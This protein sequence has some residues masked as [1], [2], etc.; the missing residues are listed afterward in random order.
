[1]KRKKSRQQR[2][3]ERYTG[4]YKYVGPGTDYKGPPVDDVD[5]AAKRH[6][7]GYA[8]IPNPYWKFNKADEEFLKDIAKSKPA[9]TWWKRRIRDQAKIL[10]TAKK[11]LGQLSYPGLPFGMESERN[12]QLI[13]NAINKRSMGEVQS[14]SLE[15]RLPSNKRRRLPPRRQPPQ[16]ALPPANPYEEKHEE[17]G[18]VPYKKRMRGRAGQTISNDASVTSSRT[19]RYT[20]K[21]KRRRLRVPRSLRQIAK[22]DRNLSRRIKKLENINKV[23]TST[24]IYK[25]ADNF[26][27][28]CVDGECAYTD[29]NCIVTADYK[30]ALDRLKFFD[31][32]TP[33]TLKEVDAAKAL[34]STSAN[35]RC[36]I[37][38]KCHLWMKNNYDHKIIVHVYVMQAKDAVSAVPSTILSNASTEVLISNFA[39]NV[40]HYPDELFSTMSWK[41]TYKVLKKKRFTITGGGEAK[42]GHSQFIKSYQANLAESGVSYND[43]SNDTLFLI[44]IQG[45]VAHDS[46]T[47]TLGS[48]GPGTV[49]ILKFGTMKVRYNGGMS[50]KYFIDQNS[51]ANITTAIQED[52]D[53]DEP[54]AH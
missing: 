39:T 32:S 12:N 16:R 24:L 49:D 25:F 43:I 44:R 36:Q 10:F 26:Q 11:I 18:L 4:G 28:T 22:A 40:F 50:V 19:K 20:R 52:T 54:D 6:D 42:F 37:F 17:K 9:A 30:Y 7:T 47:N 34:S 29:I 5:S 45:A 27:A 46:V 23:A 8:A 15:R 51:L 48:V 41:D 13:S 33:Q 1:M 38:T 2:I 53:E 31:L 21:P 3:N 14:Q 35:V